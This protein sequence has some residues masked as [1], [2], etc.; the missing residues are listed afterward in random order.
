[1]DQ[2]TQ[3]G[4]RAGLYIRVSTEEQAQHGLSLPDQRAALEAYAAGHG[5]TVAG[6]YADEGISARKGYRKRPALLRLL[7][8]VAAGRVELVLFTRLDRWFRSVGDYYEVQRVLDGAG[9]RWRAIREDYETVTASGRLKVNIM[10]SVAQDEAD[11]TGERIRAV[12]EGKRA[13]GEVL[14]GKAPLGYRI[15]GG[16]LAAD[17]ASAAVVADLFG[18]YAALRSVG[19]VRRYLLERYGLA[20]SD[21]GLRGLLSNP[22]YMGAL[23]APAIVDAGLFRL[24]Q[25][26]RQQ[27]SQRAAEGGRVYLFTGLAFCA[28]CGRRLSGHTVS[29]KYIYYRCTRYET[30]HL[31]PHRRRTGEGALEEA[32]TAA[33][34]EGLAPW[35]PRVRQAP[36]AEDPEPARVRA[37]RKLEKLRDLYLNDL[38]DR[39]SYARC[40]AALRPALEA[41]P[42][43][44]PAEEDAA[45]S[46]VGLYRQLS[47]PLKKQFWA[48]V[49]EGV[50][51]SQDG[52]FHVRWRSP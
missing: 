4:L 40:Y 3:A 41:P 48:R 49:A 38:L 14:S 42:L 8:D 27:R 52:A 21:S 45:E 17:P 39:A 22:R 43:P 18:Q 30:L 32:L 46:W 37:R 33:L 1:M 20:Y 5:L 11:R 16:R 28:E 36:A 10:L 13:R 35:E 25:Q 26:L 12:F 50:D 34:A 44:A 19:A 9:A 31:C 23:G 15:E 29:G 2:E 7:E 51:V 6:V 47:R 24:V